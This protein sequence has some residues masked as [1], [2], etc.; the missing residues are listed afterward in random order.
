MSARFT[1]PLGLWDF[2]LINRLFEILGRYRLVAATAPT[3]IVYPYV[4]TATS[5]K[6]IEEWEWID[7]RGQ[8][9]TLKVHREVE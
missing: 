1:G 7:F 8:T 3:A 2:P 9:R 6:N 5:A 4:A